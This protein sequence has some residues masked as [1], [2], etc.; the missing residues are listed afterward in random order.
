MSSHPQPLVY[1]TQ[2][3][4]SLQRAIQALM[5]VV[6]I[7]R[8]QIDTL[9]AAQVNSTPVVRPDAV[10]VCWLGAWSASLQYVRGDAVTH[11]SL[12]MVANKTTTETPSGVAVDWDLM[13]D[14]LP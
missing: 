6:A 4:A 13:A 12:L 3:P 7:Q 10:A 5:D 14:S 2:N 8:T 1:P 11:T 9:E